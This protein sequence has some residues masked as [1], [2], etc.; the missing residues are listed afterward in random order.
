MAVPGDDISASAHEVKVTLV[1]CAVVRV[2]HCPTDSKWFL[3]TDREE[4]IHLAL[5]I[6]TTDDAEA[7][8]RWW[9]IYYKWRRLYKR[10]YLLKLALTPQMFFKQKES[11]A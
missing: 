5:L 11:Y 10:F 4:T 1:K 7:R 3:H 8:A 9:Q 2:T 6:L